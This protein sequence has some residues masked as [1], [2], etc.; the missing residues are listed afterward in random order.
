MNLEFKDGKTFSIAAEQLEDWEA[1]LARLHQGMAAMADRADTLSQMI[2]LAK[3]LR[4]DPTPVQKPVHTP[5]VST[6]R[7]GRTL[8]D[9]I[10][11]VVGKSSEPMTPKMIREAI[12]KSEDASLISSENYLYTAIKR[13]ADKGDIFKEG[14]GYVQSLA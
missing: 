4:G 9:A 1:E 10:V 8:Y 13:V 14:R 6:P 2:A 5:R 3:K 12:L 7:S 11:D